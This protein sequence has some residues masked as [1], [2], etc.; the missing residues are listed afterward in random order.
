MKKL[1]FILLFISP[2]SFAQTAS[3][4]LETYLNNY[5][6]N[7]PGETG[8][9][10]SEP[11]NTQ[12]ATW[13]TVINN[14]L[15]N[16][17]TTARTNANELNYQIVEYTHTASNPNKVFYVLEEKSPSS[18]F[19]GTYVFA[20]NPTR[21]LVL[22]APHSKF[23]TN[24]GKQAVYCFVKLENRAL[25][26]NGTHRCNNST[27]SSCSGT[28]SVC[29]GSSAPFKISDLAHNQT[30][31]FQK[32]TEIMYNTLEDSFFV[33]LHGF[34]KQ[35]SD[36][37]VILSNGTN[38]NPSGTDRLIQLKNALTSVDG[39]LTFKIAHVDNWTRLVGF[40]NTQGRFINQ[41]NNPCTSSASSST[42][43]FVHV[44][45]EK[46]KLREDSS[47]WDKMYEALDIAYVATVS[48]D[49]YNQKIIFKTKNPF[50]N[51][52]SFTGNNITSY[53]IFNVLGKQVLHKKNSSNNIIIQTNHFKK[54]M[55]FLRVKT[56]NGS[57]F[58]KLIRE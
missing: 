24:T 7:I 8:N 42:G 57:I 27:E 51:S 44:E 29:T 33:Q 10:F 4:N 17:I 15:S 53:T 18:H 9:D 11:N 46:S 34:S 28:T 41:S 38:Q 21:D 19:W 2:F 56:E 35:S 52:I 26:L 47:V 14:I 39:S 58:K 13:E 36:P 1:L 12:L 16:E 30:T 55:Y 45:Q 32:T 25:F 31:A 22:Q 49:E 48:V 20:K 54:G 50:K 37:Y 5:I 23:D 3:G 6:D 40:T 43:R